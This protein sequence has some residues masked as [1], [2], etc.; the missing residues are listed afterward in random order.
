MIWFCLTVKFSLRIWQLDLLIQIGVY[1]FKNCW[2]MSTF[3]ENNF[4]ESA[5]EN[6]SWRKFNFG[7]T[8]WGK[9]GVRVHFEQFRDHHKGGPRRKSQTQKKK[10]FDR[11]LLFIDY[12]RLWYTRS[13]ISRKQYL[14]LSFRDFA[15][16]DTDWKREQLQIALICTLSAKGCFFSI[17]FEVIYWVGSFS[18]CL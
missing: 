14:D 3:V 16:K 9:V 18:R 8:P 13:H 6:I 17:F 7:K 11:N 15:A 1:S 4:Y 12:E 10:I 5:K 2:I